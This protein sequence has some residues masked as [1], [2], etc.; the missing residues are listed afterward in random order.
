MRRRTLI[1]LIAAAAAAH[2]FGGR[3]QPRKIARIGALHIGNAD[4]EAFRRE[5]RDGLR[6]L[7]HIEG[8]NIAFEF[9]SADG[10]LDRPPQLA[11]ELVGLKVDVIVALYTPCALAAK[12]AT[13]EIPIVIIAGDPL[14]T[15]LVAS[16][17]RPGNNITGLSLIAGP[18]HGKCVELLRDMLPSIRRV[19]ALGNGS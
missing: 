6:E 11:A 14:E 13:G 15:G 1:T 16:L 9:R 3:A 10:K 18:L 8:Q 12:H 4:D 19:A 2:P 17:A 7:G 5:L